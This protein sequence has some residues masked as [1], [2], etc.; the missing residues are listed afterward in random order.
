MSAKFP[1]GGGRVF[2]DRQS[3]YTY[4]RFSYITGCVTCCKAVLSVLCGVCATPPLLDQLLKPTVHSRYAHTPFGR[5]RRTNGRSRIYSFVCIPV[6]SY[7]A[8]VFLRTPFDTVWG[9]PINSLCALPYQ[10]S[11]SSP[12][13]ISYKIRMIQN[14]NYAQEWKI[15]SHNRRLKCD[16]KGIG[17]V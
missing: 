5:E 8:S 7:S 11:N 10:T 12:G 17:G 9:S 15:Y 13:S 2:F 4:L 1:R 16:L 14:P 3:I 6:S